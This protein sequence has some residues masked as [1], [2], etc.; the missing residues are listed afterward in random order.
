MVRYEISEA[1]KSDKEE[2]KAQTES[3]RTSYFMILDKSSKQ[4]F[5]TN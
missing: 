4:I 5:H 1:D 2:R 3:W